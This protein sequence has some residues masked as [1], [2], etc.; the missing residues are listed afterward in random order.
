MSKRFTKIICLNVAVVAALG[1]AAAYGCGGYYGGRPLSGDISG[2]VVQGTNGGFAVEKGGYV[3]F[4]NGIES[5]EAVNDYGKPEKGAIYRI[6]KKDLSDHNYASVDCVAPVV[7]YT[8]DYNAGLFIYGDYVYY[9][10]PSTA[11]SSDGS[12]LNE[13]LDMK[14]TK[15]DGTETMKNAY[16]Q[17]PSNEYEYRYVEEGGTVYLMYVASE[18]K[19][20]EEATAVKNLHSYNTVTGTDT[21][22][23]YNVDTVIFDSADKTNPRVYYTMN[24]KNYGADANFGYNQVYTVKADATEDKFAN[25]KFDEIIDG[26][27]GDEDDAARDR[28]INCGDLVF[29][30][31]GLADVLKN[32]N[33]GTPFNYDATGKI[34]NELSLTY[35][36]ANYQNETLFYTRTSSNNDGKYLF[37]VSDGKITDKNAVERNADSDDAILTDGSA[38]DG[39]KYI[40]DGSNKLKLVLIQEEDGITVNKVSANGKLQQK[41]VGG[42]NY[43][44]IVRSTATIL[45]TEE[46]YLYYSV[47]G[48]NGYTFNR[49]NYAAENKDVYGRMP[50]DDEVDE[51]TSVKLL[52][53]DANT[54]WFM[55]EIISGQLLFSSETD[56]MTSYNYV[57]AFDLRKDRTDGVL[58]SNSDIYALNKKYEGISEIFEKYDDKDKY[59]EKI[60]ANLSGALKYAFYTGDEAYIKELAALCN[61]DVKEKDKE[62]DD[63]YSEKTLALVAD[64]IKPAADNDWKDYTGVAKVN[65]SDVYANRREYYYGVLGKMTERDSEGYIDALKAEYLQSEPVNDKTWWEGLSTGAKVGFVIG[66]CACGLIVLGGAAVLTVFIIRRKKNKRPVYRKKINVDTTDDKNIDVYSDENNGNE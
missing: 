31:I 38:A 35:S 10:T 26:W 27:N 16:V 20:Y 41:P 12:V 58:M 54:E 36:L 28:Y 62:A 5:N 40:F 17:F 15:L 66:M 51:Y 11:K 19:L 56:K 3:Y 47:S 23:A 4:I 14:R 33:A 60:Y 29:D 34:H 65:G 21:V 13:N 64:F 44:Y 53:L 8:A 32:N 43:Y 50:E 24:V 48:G 42:D 1:V 49:I 9:G 18:E 30:G 7:A 45:F 63:V 25:V 46:N 39:Y 55:P 37:S 59:D 2:T 57:M 52:D 22:L 61:A 6:S